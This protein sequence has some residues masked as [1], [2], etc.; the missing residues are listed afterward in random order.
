MYI[1]MLSM[2]D[3]HVACVACSGLLGAAWPMGGRPASQEVRVLHEQHHAEGVGGCRDDRH[4]DEGSWNLCVLWTQLPRYRGDP[5]QGVWGI[6]IDLLQSDLESYGGLV[7]LVDYL[8][9]YHCLCIIFTYTYMWRE[10]E[11]GKNIGKWL[12]CSFYHHNMNMIY[13]SLV[14]ITSTINA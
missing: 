6:L 1:Y 14:G 5:Y 12:M 10:K 3:L 7:I 2:L 11:V 13:G 9:F 8:D 4:G